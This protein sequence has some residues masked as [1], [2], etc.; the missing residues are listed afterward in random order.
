MQKFLL[1]VMAL[2]ALSLG[3]CASVRA[4]KAIQFT[5]GCG[6]HIKRAANAGT[7]GLA[8]NE[9]SRA[10]A[11]AEKKGLTNGFT[12]VLYRTP[13]D[14]VGFWYANI[15]ASLAELRKVKEDTPQLERSNLLIKLR[16]TLTDSGKESQRVVAPGGISI[17]RS[18]ALYFWWLLVSCTVF[19]LAF[20]V[21]ICTDI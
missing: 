21:Y 14:D 9:L 1:T 11:Y 16:E 18:N 15:A 2:A 7:V 5:Q 8:E 17:H 10:A 20:G 4:V 3:V 19:V 13:S 12:S 6:G